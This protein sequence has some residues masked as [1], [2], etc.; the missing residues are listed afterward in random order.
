M[1]TSSKKLPLL[2]LLL[3]LPAVVQAQSYTNSYGI[4]Y[5]TTTSNTITIT[6]YIGRGGDVTIPDRIPDTTNSL[7]VTTIGGYVYD[8]FGDRNGAFG[9]C[10]GLICITI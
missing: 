8:S 3:T 1:K 9:E 2:L 6:Q 7:Q 5:Y 10:H 4:W